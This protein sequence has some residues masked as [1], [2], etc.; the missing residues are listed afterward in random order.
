M[1]EG[2]VSSGPLLEMVDQGVRSKPALL[3]SRV[4]FGLYVSCEC[5]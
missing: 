5:K 4:Q 3:V 2:P 1:E